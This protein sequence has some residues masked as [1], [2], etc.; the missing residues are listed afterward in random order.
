LKAGA[1]ALLLIASTA[2]AAPERIVSLGGSVTETVYALGRGQE[3]VAVDQ[4]SQYP[5][6]TQKLPNIGR[7]EQASAEGI[8]AQKPTLLLALE[9]TGPKEALAALVAAGVRVEIIPAEK[10]IAGAK[11]RIE[12]LG[13]L[14]DRTREAS[15]LLG[16]LEQDLALAKI[17]V[18]HLKSAPKV[19]FV[20]ARSA[21]SVQVAG[22]GTGAAAIISLAG[23]A[24]ATPEL[25]EYRPLSAEGLLAA[26]P[27]VMLFTERGLRLIGGVD[28]ALGIAGVADTPAGK[29]R[30]IVAI[31]DNLLLSFGPRVGEAVRRLAAELTKA[32]GSR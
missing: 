23:G 16:Q 5:E 21:G 20:Y 12:K 7:L 22:Q 19:M 32:E 28:A 18:A 9:G 29:N 25:K 10:S 11:A 2:E 31:E 24:L 3:V 15:T 26:Q 1:L 4:T 8:L 27:E 30:R 13:A 17:E 6:V 14:L